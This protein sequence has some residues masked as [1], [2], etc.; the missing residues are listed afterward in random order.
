MTAEKIDSELKRLSQQ[1]QADK[2]PDNIL[3]MEAACEI[4]NLRAMYNGILE[5]LIRMRERKSTIVATLQKQ[6]SDKCDKA[7]I[8]DVRYKIGYLDCTN[9]V[10]TLMNEVM[11]E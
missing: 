5:D 8:N 11:G 10:I 6:C 7:E 9:D 2:N 4:Q 3:I 1:M